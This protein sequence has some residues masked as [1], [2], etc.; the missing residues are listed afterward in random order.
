[1]ASEAIRKDRYLESDS[2]SDALLGDMFETWRNYSIFIQ[3]IVWILNIIVWPPGS[4]GGKY[5]PLASIFLVIF[6]LILYAREHKIP[7]RTLIH[8]FIIISA[9]TV[10]PPSSSV[11]LTIIYL[12]QAEILTIIFNKIKIILYDVY[13]CY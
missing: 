11:N 8:I 5:L 12:A 9:D 7:A 1:M 10:T 4:R 13:Q 6:K 3:Q 2:D